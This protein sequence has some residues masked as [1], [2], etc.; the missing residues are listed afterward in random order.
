MIGLA[1]YIAGLLILIPIAFVIIVALMGG[2]LALP[3]FLTK[4]WQSLPEVRKKEIRHF[5]YLLWF[6]LI[7][8]FVLSYFGLLGKIPSYLWMLLIIII[9]GVGR[10]GF[11][12]L[13]KIELNKQLKDALLL[14]G[15][16]TGA[17]ILLAVV[18]Y[19]YITIFIPH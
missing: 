15:L 17:F 8:V 9:T 4:K 18:F 11:I 16:I 13:T 6:I 2:S 19:L 12:P 10:K 3:F 5:F 1:F 14:A 7:G